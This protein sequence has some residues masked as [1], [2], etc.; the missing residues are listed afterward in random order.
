M[1]ID[2]KFSKEFYKQIN[3]SVYKTIKCV[4]VKQVDIVFYSR[5]FFKSPTFLVFLFL[6]KEILNFSY[7]VNLAE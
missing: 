2:E 7:A 4:P 6:V 3:Y 5:I 1:D